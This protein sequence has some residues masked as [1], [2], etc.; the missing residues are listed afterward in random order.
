MQGP[1]R[2]AFRNMEAPIGVEAE[3][4]DRVEDLEL[5]F[6]HI[7]A[8]SIVVEAQH[9]RHRQGRFYQVR[10]VM[11]V[12]DREIVVRRDPADNHAHEE[13]P[14]VIRNSFDAARRQLQDHARITRGDVKLHAAVA[15]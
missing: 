3:V 13:L 7:I 4:R 9:R 11:T 15:E 12:P 8:C 14:V 6:K 5:V 1:L 2:I 10:I